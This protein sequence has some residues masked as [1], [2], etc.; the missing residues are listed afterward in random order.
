MDK[1]VAPLSPY[2][3]FTR[4]E[5]AALR[6][7]TPL[8]LSED[9]VARLRSL[10]DPISLD[11]VI[12][13][14]LPLSRLLSLYVAATQGLYKATQRFLGAEG[15]NVPYIIAVAGSVA[16]GKSTLARVMQA[17]LQRWPNTPKVDL[18]T[19]DGFLYPNALLE[20]EG[21]MARKGFPESYDGT[22][23]LS[24]VIDVKAGKRK[25]EAPVYSHV[26]YDIVPGE[27]IVIDRPDILIL[28]GLNVLS[29]ER[30]PRSGRAMPFLSDFFDFSVYLHAAEE[31]LEQWFIARFMRLR[32][33]SFH[34][35]ASYFKKYA[36]LDDALAKAVARDIW[37]R[38]NLPNLRENI[39]PTLPR[40]SL[41]LTKG[42][43]HF[44]KEVELRKL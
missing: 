3:H 21:L 10:D 34:D 15:G 16:A 5:W 11:E 13:I 26:T 41:V 18:V 32:D 44:I 29:A 17:L 23:L 30:T 43:D 4:E 27:S 39:L 8:T 25:V 9:E 33:T 24:F 28:E 36:S 6:A 12:A 40:A 1:R 22:R 38:I 19:T 37:R 2:H 7:E 20:R 42:P 35:P 31:D 14:Y